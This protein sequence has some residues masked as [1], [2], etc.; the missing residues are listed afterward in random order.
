[1]SRPTQ[2]FDS[3]SSGDALATLQALSL[4]GLPDAGLITEGELQRGPPDVEVLFA[5]Y[6]TRLSPAALA[7]VTGWVA[8][9]G[10][11]V[12]D[13]FLASRGPNGEAVKP[14][15]GGLA[16]LFGVGS[17]MTGTLWSDEGMVGAKPGPELSGGKPSE[18][19]SLSFFSGGFR[20]KALPGTV[21]LARYTTGDLPA[22]TMRSVGA[23]KAILVPRVTVLEQNLGH[24]V[25]D[26]VPRPEIRELR[27]GRSSQHHNGLFFANMLKALLREAGAEAPARLV[28][29][30]V[31]K[32]GLD[33]Q[34]AIVSDANV[35]DWGLKTS[36]A[37]V[38]AT[39]SGL[40]YFGRS[41]LNNLAREWLLD[42]DAYA[43]V[44]VSMLEAPASSTSAAPSRLVL[45]V[46]ESSWPRNAVLAVPACAAL[47]DLQTGED[48][49]PQQ[50]QVTVPLAGYQVRLLALRN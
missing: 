7:T 47:T 17:A 45:A 4:A 14:L 46:H 21:V 40:P 32:A 16:Q 11:L 37:I 18:P 23:G 36:R 34:E 43:P 41:E 39:Q 5:P 20:L 25:A 3:P 48:F 31:S 35:P 6:V 42:L 27:M 30:P 29:A 13:S 1:M 49:R 15:G 12:A 2:L 22:V 28:R 24:L 44:R 33:A 9:G 10:I 26:I 50:G 8:T 38:E 19:I